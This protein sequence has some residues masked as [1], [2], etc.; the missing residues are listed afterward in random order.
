MEQRYLDEVIE[1]I[2]ENVMGDFEVSSTKSKKNNG[3]ELSG[4]IIR[5][6]SNFNKIEPVFYVDEYFENGYTAKETARLI[7]AKYIEMKEVGEPSFDVRD[8]TNF[9]IVKGRLK[10]KV[11]NASLNEKYLVDKPHIKCADDLVATFIIDVNS[12]GTATIP[13]T[14]QLM[15]IWGIESEKDLYAVTCDNHSRA[16]LVTMAEAIIDSISE[17]EL[18][19]MKIQ[20]GNENLSTEEFKR[21]LIESQYGMPEMYVWKDG[22]MFGA[23]AILYQDNIDALLERIKG[24]CVV[25]PSSIHELIVIKYDD[26]YSIEE[27]KDMIGSV[28]EQE[29]RPEEVLSDHPYIITEKGEV[30]AVRSN[31]DLLKVSEVQVGDER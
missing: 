8:I 9:D 21:L 7:L 6:N 2:Q 27:L 4:V 17:I 23:S 10:A 25:L 11:I 22:N 1:I 16:E 24:R 18:E 12:D 15:E 30:I 13:V 29:L 3:L 26:S 19:A 31:E 14:K 28:N 20:S 5:D